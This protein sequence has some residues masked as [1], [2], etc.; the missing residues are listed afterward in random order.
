MMNPL[1]WLPLITLGTIALA[2]PVAWWSAIDRQRWLLV[3]SYRR[4]RPNVEAQRHIA[5][6]DNLVKRRED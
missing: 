5:W 6:A 1:P 3:R 2:L 4:H